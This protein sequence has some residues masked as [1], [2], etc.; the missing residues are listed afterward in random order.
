MINKF[1]FVDNE[2]L[3]AQDPALLLGTQTVTV[4]LSV[5]ESLMIAFVTHFA[6]N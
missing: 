5:T 1:I 6:L 2:F 3:F 4:I